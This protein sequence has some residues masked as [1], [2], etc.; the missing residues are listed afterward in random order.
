M[1]VTASTAALTAAAALSLGRLPLD[2]VERD[3]RELTA[4]DETKK[5]IE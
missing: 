1:I 2:R 4:A 5:E 3:K